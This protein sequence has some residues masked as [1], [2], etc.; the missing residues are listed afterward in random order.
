MQNYSKL[1]FGS[2][3]ECKKHLVRE[4]V[5]RR[6]KLG[7]SR[8]VLND[9][10]VAAAVGK[11]LPKLG[12]VER[13]PQKLNALLAHHLLRGLDIGADEVMAKRLKHYL[14]SKSN[15]KDTIEEIRHEGFLGDIH[16]LNRQLLMR[17]HVAC[18]VLAE[19]GW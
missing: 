18:A 2:V 15:Q 10:C 9:F 17:V 6:K 13:N 5:R 7:K 4:F 11:K 3:E 19:L 16:P 8:K 14:Q 1:L 12:E